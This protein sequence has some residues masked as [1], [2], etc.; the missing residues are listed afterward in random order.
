MQLETEFT[1]AG[2]SDRMADCLLPR[3]C[4]TTFIAFLRWAARRGLEGEE[5]SSL[6]R[7][8]SAL[9]ARTR[10]RDLT[11]DGAVRRAF[12]ELAA[13]DLTPSP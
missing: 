5:L 6:W 12:A 11:E 13:S 2:G 10:G 3:D 9:M 8:G 4:A 7:T 1:T